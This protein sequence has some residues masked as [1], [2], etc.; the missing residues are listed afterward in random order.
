MRS[1]SNISLKNYISFLGFNYMYDPIILEYHWK[2]IQK[3]I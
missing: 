3:N 2:N 1:I